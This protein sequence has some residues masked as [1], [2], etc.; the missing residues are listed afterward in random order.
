MKNFPFK[1]KAKL[2][3][4][5]VEDISHAVQKESHLFEKRRE[6]HDEIV[7]QGNNTSF[8]SSR[9]KKKDFLKTKTTAIRSVCDIEIKFKQATI[10]F[11]CFNKQNFYYFNINSICLSTTI[12]KTKQQLNQNFVK[13]CKQNNLG[14]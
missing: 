13:V 4:K 7:S 2:K 14:K 3:S 5:K 9:E 1:L 8:S 11:N 10:L 6:I 12:L